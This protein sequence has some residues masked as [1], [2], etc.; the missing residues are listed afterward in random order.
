[1]YLQVFCSAVLFLGHNIDAVC[2]MP[3]VVFV[4]LCGQLHLFDMEMLHFEPSPWQEVYRSFYTATAL[5]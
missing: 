2:A 5:L 1:M 4:T 3:L